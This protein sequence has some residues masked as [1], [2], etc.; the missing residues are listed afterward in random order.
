MAIQTEQHTQKQYVRPGAAGECSPTTLGAAIEHAA[1]TIPEFGTL[2]TWQRLSGFS[3]TAT[4]DALGAGDLRAVK[5]GKRILIDIR[6]GLE[7]LR[8]LPPVKIRPRRQKAE[9]A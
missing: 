1:E 9:A 2:E 4:Y 7:Y 3:R 8:S 5:R 6:H